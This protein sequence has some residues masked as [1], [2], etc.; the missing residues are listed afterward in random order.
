VSVRV[1]QEAGR[2]VIR[3]ADDGVGIAPELLPRIFEAFT[4][5]EATLHRT[6]GGLGL[7]LA[8][9]KGIVELH[10]GEVEALSE[11]PGRGAEITVRLPLLKGVAVEPQAI[12]AAATPVVRCRVLVVEDNLD[13]AEMLKEGLELAGHEV[14]VAHD[15]REGLARAR[16][17]RPDVVLCDIGLPGLDGYEWRVESARTRRSLRTS[18]R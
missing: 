4:Q 14:V 16:S 6:L 13:A 2:A 1:G 15:G 11:G 12:P 18:S 9:V 8:L 10:G 7:G 17:L 3:V 5:A